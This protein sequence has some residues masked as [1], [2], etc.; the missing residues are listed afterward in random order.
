M[1]YSVLITVMEA[2]ISKWKYSLLITVIGTTIPKWKYSVLIGKINTKAYKNAE[3]QKYKK[4]NIL[5]LNWPRHKYSVFISV[6]IWKYIDTNTVLSPLLLVS[7]SFCWVYILLTLGVITCVREN[8]EVIKCPYHCSITI[9]SNIKVD[10]YHLC[11]R[12]L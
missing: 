7:L 11:W 2:K 4:G 8:T 5:S 9:R 1:K 6:I 10:I 3:L 12:M